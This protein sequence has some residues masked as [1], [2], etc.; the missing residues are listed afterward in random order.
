MKLLFR[1]LTALLCAAPLLVLSAADPL[2]PAEQELLQTIRARTLQGHISF[3][4]ADSLEGR[5][6][7]S[8]G[9]DVAADYIASQF[10]RFGLQ[11]GSGDSYFQ[12]A[13]FVRAKQPMDQF[14]FLLTAGD[15]QFKAAAEHTAVSAER[16]FALV[17]ATP[18]M[19][20]ASGENAALPPASDV[21]GK[22]VVL[23]PGE[24]RGRA[25]FERR[26]A[27]LALKPAA[28]IVSGQAF[29]MREQLREAGSGTPRPP[30]IT[31]S[32]PAFASLAAKIDAKSKLSLSI[33]A[34]VEEP[35]P[36]KNVAAILPGSDPVLAKTY[37]IL[38]AHY[39]HTGVNPRAEGDK[40]N[41]GA[42]DD[43]SGVATV[44]AIAEALS[45]A[46]QR[47]KRSILFIT[48]FGEEKGLL[49][50]RYYAAHPLVA[51]AQTAG[52][53]NFEHMGRT[54]DNEGS[55]A[56]K[57][58]STGFDYTTLGQ[59]LSDAAKLTG[60]EPWK[61]ER[62]S[63]AFFGSSDNQSLANAGVPAITVS[64]SYI[65]PDYHRAGDHWDKIDYANMER[66][67]RTCAL[68]AF[69]VT[70]AAQEPRWVEANPRTANYVKTWRELHGAQ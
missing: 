44:L 16:A 47:P 51:L 64:V 21:A 54:D 65:F 7:P 58:T 30:V 57:L 11:P 42:N 63:D 49:G 15:G 37:I 35:V 61:H 17:D 23:L 20:Q 26:A 59:D 4:A 55:R 45:A 2:S 38:S 8:R 56:G 48:Y 13:A 32:D 29:M 1:P 6:T 46:P 22:A 39:D 41:N 9:L 40:I 60:I 19:I 50:S 25:L 43:A 18:V 33:Q 67:V 10:R 53:L 24:L 31:I 27:I 36:L 70:N 62:N 12:N 14:S 52:N 5:D 68:T 69:R 34:P 28:L 3:L 66:V